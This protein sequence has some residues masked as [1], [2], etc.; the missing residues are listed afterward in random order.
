[1]RT[2]VYFVVCMALLVMSL[3]E[4]IFIVRLV[5]KQD[6]QQPVPAWLRHLVLERVALLLCLGEQS[7][8][9]RPP[10]TSQTTKTDDCSG[11]K[12]KG[13]GCGDMVE[14]LWL[15]VTCPSLGGASNLGAVLHLAPHA[16]PHWEAA[17]FSQR[18]QRAPFLQNLYLLSSAWAWVERGREFQRLSRSGAETSGLGVVLL[19]DGPQREAIGCHPGSYGTSYLM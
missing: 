14:S 1:M 10:A 16:R 15:D 18:P 5:H 2:G 7:A 8:S 13:P 11:E 17:E 12:G 4:T 3:A 9:R 19:Q 6:L